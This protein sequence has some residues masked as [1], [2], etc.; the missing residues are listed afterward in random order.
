VLITRAALQIDSG[1][2]AYPLIDP[3]IVADTDG[4]GFIPADAALQI[5]EAGVNYPTATLPSP[6]IPS[7]TVFT[8]LVSRAAP[9]T[10]GFP[11]APAFSVATVQQ[12]FTTST[13]TR[14]HVKP[15]P[16]INVSWMDA[17]FALSYRRRRSGLDSFAL[18]VDNPY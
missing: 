1:F 17:F 5:N 11:A 7:G 13:S 16:F 8:P 12:Q 15:Q 10:L 6:P 2:T 3:V 18:I 4:S 14:T 9:H